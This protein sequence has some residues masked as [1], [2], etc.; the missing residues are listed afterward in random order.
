MA[1]TPVTSP[2]GHY[3][4]VVIGLTDLVMT[5]MGTQMMC[6]DRLAHLHFHLLCVFIIL[7]HMNT[8][9]YGADNIVTSC[10][11]DVQFSA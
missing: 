11:S 2:T 9:R 1:A 7:S 5:S 3:P 4:E 10:S 6:I 8:H